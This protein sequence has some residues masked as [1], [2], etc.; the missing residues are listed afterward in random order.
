M[1]VILNKCF[2]GFSLSEKA[3]AQLNCSMYEYSEDLVGLRSDYNLVA[4]V[5]R[6]GDEADGP[7]ASLKKVWMPDDATD[8][9]IHEY[10]GYETLIYV[11]DGK[12]HYE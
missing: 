5:D 6:L 2:G 9:D 4:C 11:L 7:C 12:L 10:D 3:C 1:Y 8:W